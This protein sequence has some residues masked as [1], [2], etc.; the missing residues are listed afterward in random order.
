MT[1]PKLRSLLKIVETGSYTRAAEALALSQPAVSQHIRALEEELGVRL[2]EHARGRFKLTPEGE[3][4]AAY[5]RR[6]EAQYRT[7]IAQ[8]RAGAAELRVITCGI[9]HS[10]ESGAVIEALASAASRYDDLSLKL[11]TKTTDKLLQMVKNCELDFAVVEGGSA[12]PDLTGIPVDTDFLVLVTAPDHPLAGL[13]TVPLERL[14]EEKLIL[15]L[16][17][18]NTR[19]LFKA[20][21]ESQNRS[22][23]EFNVV[24]EI[25]SVASIKDLVRRGFGVSVLSK[26]ACM[27]EIR[28]GKLKALSIEEMPMRRDVHLVCRRDYRHIDFLESVAETYRRL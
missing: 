17:D 6:E 23:D 26:S 8:L 27:D 4:V 9:T 28:K 20:S 22:V 19:N 13:S 21:L 16:P 24:M 1:D 14:K 3:T 5:A 15:R 11:L 12:D 10:A 25:D 18:S 7:L 2:F